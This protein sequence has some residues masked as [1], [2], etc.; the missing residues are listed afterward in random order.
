[1]RLASIAIKV[2]DEF[3][4]SRGQQLREGVR[5]SLQHVSRIEDGGL[6]I[7]R[8][9]T[10]YGKSL[11]SMFIASAVAEVGHELGLARVTHVL[12]LRSIVQDL[13]TKARRYA[14]CGL[15]GSLRQNDISYQAS[16]YL[17][18]GYK[19]ELFLSKLVYTTLDSYVINFSKITPLRSRWAS[20]HA[21]RTAIYTALTIFDEAHLFAEVD[22]T[23]AYTSLV[24]IV[25]KLLE[26]RLP[27]IVMTATMPDSF[28][29]SLVAH[30]QPHNCT[31]ISMD[32]AKTPS[33]SVGPCENVVFQDSSWE[34]PS[35]DTQLKQVEDPIKD[36]ARLAK[37]EAY[38]GRVLI[39][40]NKV[41]LAIKTYK[42]LINEGLPKERVV[43]LH[44]RLTYGDRDSVLS[45]VTC[46][47]TLNHERERW[48]CEDEHECRGDEASNI[49]VSTQVIEAGVDFSVDTLISDIAPLAQL[50]QRVGRVARH[51]R[52]GRAG[53]VFIVHQDGSRELYEHVYDVDITRRTLE[54]LK[55]R[56]NSDKGGVEIEWRIPNSQDESS[57]FKLLNDVYFEYFKMVKLDYQVIDAL[58]KIDEIVTLHRRDADEIEGRLCGFVRESVMVPFIVDGES[59]ERRF[60]ECIERGG[61]W[62]DCYNI[63]VAPRLLTIDHEHFCDILSKHDILAMR[64]ERGLARIG[65]LFSTPDGIKLDYVNIPLLSRIKEIRDW[66][67]YKEKYCRLFMNLDH[68]VYRA[69][70]F[71]GEFK[72]ESEDEVKTY[73]G[74]IGLVLKD[75]VYEDGVGLKVDI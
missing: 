70:R 13:Y 41:N 4:G 6:L 35:Y 1:V 26:A 45:R 5:L 55:R 64:F 46:R 3:F 75:G 52:E 17:D 72:D 24:T 29:E 18:E 74:F 48:G 14:S 71:K 59:A 73:R 19:S 9:P 34:P 27:V 30:I 67:K 65:V 47:R 63:Y 32:W 57:Y 51:E 20:Y 62:L 69:L 21:A 25:R 7:I 56:A 44:G 38:N 61:G 53:K 58:E 22:T 54:V 31:V 37:E 8:L 36:I 68:E 16:I 43:L 15:L 10:G 42:R 60:N 11:M 28:V 2:A 50:V 66:R 12:P 33:S 39:V 49:I 40:R 23:K